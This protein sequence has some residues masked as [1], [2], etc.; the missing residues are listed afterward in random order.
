MDVTMDIGIKCLRHQDE[1]YNYCFNLC[2]II[3]S[4]NLLFKYIEYRNIKMGLHLFILIKAGEP[5]PPQGADSPVLLLI[6]GHF[7]MDMTMDPDSY[8]DGIGRP[9]R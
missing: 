9:R 3:T 4:K 7:T 5:A 2:I 1:T 8:R 6:Y